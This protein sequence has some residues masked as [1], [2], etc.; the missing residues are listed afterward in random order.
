MDGATGNGVAFKAGGRGAGGGAAG[1]GGASAASK[2]NGFETIA[3]VGAGW[4]GLAAI[5]F[6]NGG[7]DWAAG[8]GTAP[9]GSGIGAGG[10]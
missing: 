9:A 6:C 10:A 4:I 7:G 5:G 2:A 3:A 1:G 8:D